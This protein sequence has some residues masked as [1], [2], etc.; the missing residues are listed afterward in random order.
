MNDQ[1]PNWNDIPNVLQDNIRNSFN[2]YFNDE[3]FEMYVRGVIDDD[4]IAIEECL[5]DSYEYIEDCY[6]ELKM[7]TGDDEDE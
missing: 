7:D 1:I 5:K 3:L 6:L 2:R 4:E